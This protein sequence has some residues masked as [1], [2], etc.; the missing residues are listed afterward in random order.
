VIGRVPEEAR[1]LLRLFRLK[2]QLERLSITRLSLRGDVYL[3]EY[4]DRIALER[5]LDL[6]RAELRPVRAGLAHLVLPESRRQPAQALA[7]FESLLMRGAPA[8]KIAGARP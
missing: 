6:S 3:L 5:G 4:G 7:W 8:A 1:D 2:A